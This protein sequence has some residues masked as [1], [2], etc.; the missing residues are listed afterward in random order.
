MGRKVINLICINYVEIVGFEYV[1]D[2]IVFIFVVDW[3]KYFKIGKVKVFYCIF[4]MLNI[5]ESEIIWVVFDLFDCGGSHF[6][7]FDWGIEVYILMVEF[8]F[9]WGF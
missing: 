2:F 8:E 3:V 4:V 6:I 5:V 1:D 7:Y 9:E